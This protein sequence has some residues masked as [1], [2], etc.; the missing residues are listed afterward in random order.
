MNY[1][2]NQVRD[3]PDDPFDVG[4]GPEDEEEDA[5]Q[6][7]DGENYVGGDDPGQEQDEDSDDEYNRQNFLGEDRYMMND[8]EENYDEIENYEDEDV[9][10]QEGQEQHDDRAAFVEQEHHPPAA[11]TGSTSRIISQRA[12]TSGSAELGLRPPVA[13]AI[14]PLIVPGAASTF[15]NKAT[16]G[17]NAAASVGAGAARGSSFSLRPLSSAAPVVERSHAGSSSLNKVVTNSNIKP[18][19]F[20]NYRASNG[21]FE[22]HNYSNHRR[23]RNG[24][25]VWEKLQNHPVSRTF[26]QVLQNFFC[27]PHFATPDMLDKCVEY[28]PATGAKGKSL[29]K[30]F[31][32]FT[33]MGE[34]LD[35]FSTDESHNAKDPPKFDATLEQ[36]T[37]ISSD[38][39]MHVNYDARAAEQLYRRGNYLAHYFYLSRWHEEKK[40]K[41]EKA[42]AVR[43]LDPNKKPTVLMVAEKPSIAKILAEHLNPSYRP[44]ANG[45]WQKRGTLSKG[46]PTFEFNG[47]FKEAN[48]QCKFLITSTIGHC[49]TLGF[50]NKPRNPYDCFDTTTVKELE[51]SATK[52]RIPEHLRDL[53]READ[54]LVLWLDCDKEGENICFEVISLLRSSATP[55]QQ[56]PGSEINPRFEAT[57]EHI[58][59]AH[60]SALT[61]PELQQAMANLKRP[62]K[63]LSMSVDARQLLDFRV[64]IAFTKLLTW[65]FLNH[66]KQKFSWIDNTCLSYGPCQT[67]TLWFCIE[68]HKEIQRF[69]PEKWQ[70]RTFT[71]QLGGG[72]SSTSSA[73]HHSGHRGGAGNSSRYNNSSGSS[74]YQQSITDK[75][76]EFK[77]KSKAKTSATYLQNNSRNN[78]TTATLLSLDYETKKIRKPAGLNTVELLKQA[79][80]LGF[81]PASAM[82]TAEELYSAGLISYPRTESTKYASSYNVDEI[83]RMF[84]HD[85]KLRHSVQALLNQQS[86]S[87]AR[88]RPPQDGFDRGD[89]PPIT[90]MR[91]PGRGENLKPKAWK[92]FEL[93]AKHF[94]ASLFNDIEYVEFTAKA[95]L[96]EAGGG[97]RYGSNNNSGKNTSTDS[98][99]TFE[100][101]F[102][103][104][105]PTGGRARDH[106]TSTTNR[107]ASS[108]NNRGAPGGGSSSYNNYSSNGNSNSSSPAWQNSFLHLCEH[109]GKFLK[110]LSNH[111]L[112]NNN[113]QLLKSH[114]L[115][116]NTRFSN[117]RLTSTETFTEPPQFL[118]ESELVG[119]MDKNGIGTDASMAGHIENICVRNYVSVCGPGEKGSKEAGPRVMT[120]GMNKGKLKSGEWP[121]SRHLVPTGLGLAVLD[122]VQRSVPEL[123]D[124]KIRAYMEKQCNQI[125]DGV[126]SK[127]TVVTENIK[128]FKDK[129]RRLE[130][131]LDN[132]RHIL[133][134]KDG[135]GGGGWMNNNSSS[136]GGG[137]YGNNNKSSNFK[138]GSSGASFGGKGAK[139]SKGSAPA[140]K[141]ARSGPY[142]TSSMV[143]GGGGN[144]SSKNTKNGG[145]DSK[146][147]GVKKGNDKGNNSTF[148]GGKMNKGTSSSKGKGNVHQSATGS[149][150]I[151]LGGGGGK[152]GGAGGGK[153]STGTKNNNS[154]KG[155][156]GLF[157]NSATT[158]GKNK[159]GTTTSA[160]G[161]VHDSA[162]GS[163]DIP[164]GNPN[165]GLGRSNNNSSSWGPPPPMAAGGAG[166]K[167]Q[168][169]ATTT[170]STQQ[171]AQQVQQALYQNVLQQQNLVLQQLY[172]QMGAF[173][174]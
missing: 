110:V 114:Y 63:F 134:P 141:N 5:D 108:Y 97:G 35:T 111:T 79:S 163:N 52:C 49:F 12:A 43:S 93:V 132:V 6:Q 13:K 44:S 154:S 102:H 147:G 91:I 77:C 80:F 59:R 9:A 143:V 158:S 169:S 17:D 88:I 8:E 127:D 11:P 76:I 20:H 115:A 140:G 27:G 29:G 133:A 61:K 25:D 57:D 90:P 74:S 152:F 32:G 64:G 131:N 106:Y 100:A 16:H 18:K 136:S 40:E 149:N 103:Y 81:S 150:D 157:G 92:M 51:P 172:N 3:M 161:R 123:V 62:N 112:T 83:A 95:R 139:N 148:A 60:F 125:S 129:F 34:L 166:G 66:A 171:S 137:F 55:G 165:K 160:K 174:K 2:E 151:P 126:N 120:K 19:I 45:P 78:S 168:N 56:G 69:V 82:R 113:C 94:I 33:L 46:V 15:A 146:G 75:A 50:Q 162:T 130:G 164:L 37:L 84:Q 117:L 99:N 72:G 21:N 159:K 67:P 10:A 107:G 73:G 142:G 124:P 26:P 30:I 116:K 109:K 22:S 4:V 24:Q 68:R 156:G 153:S 71:P 89:H 38:C 105:V 119:L 86:G 7:Q 28:N 167:N 170:S 42:Q 70:E 155:N 1:E 65:N 54:Y 53:G 39:A 96:D 58:Y 121:K 173:T 85:N 101:V 104:L 144:K 138:G 23:I 98:E 122:I 36:D 47:F 41:E 31:E 135:G 145:K 118:S 128:V 14:A 87:N 48:K